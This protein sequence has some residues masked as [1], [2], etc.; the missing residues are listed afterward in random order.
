MENLGLTSIDSCL[1]SRLSAG[2]AS[3]ELPSDIF[4]AFQSV[5][6]KILWPKGSLLLVEG[7]SPSG[8]Y[9]LN[10]GRAMLSSCLGDGRKLIARFAGAGEVFGLSAAISNKPYEITVEALTPCQVTFVERQR[11]LRFLSEHAQVCLIVSELLSRDYRNALEQVRILALIHSAARKLAGLLLEWCKAVGESNEQ[12]ILLRHVPPTRDEIA[13]IIGASC[14]AVTLLLGEFQSGKI[15]R[16]K[17]STI[18]VRDR[19]SLE[20]VAN[21]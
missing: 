14:H 3:Y 6:Q 16:V 8:I 4:E 11:L 20:R 1:C 10:N 5:G 9:L 13:Q 12:G 15:I 2:Q 7:L 21:S 17:G 18:L 19:L